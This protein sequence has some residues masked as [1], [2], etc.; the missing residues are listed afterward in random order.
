M[1]LYLGC[2]M[3]PFHEQHITVMGDPD[4]WTWV[5]KFVRHPRVKDWDATNLWQVDDGTA[6]KI[7][8]SHLLEHFPHTKV[9]DILWHWYKKLAKGGELIINVP[10]LAWAA[11]RLNKLDQGGMLDGYYNRFDGDR[12][13]LAIFYGT[14]SH[15]GEYHQAGFIKQYLHDLLLEI[16]FKEVTVEQMEDAHDM[17]VLFARAIK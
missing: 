12:G 13:L 17:G 10:D 9:K 4:A 8:A 3:P 2:A 11:R 1:K 6:E 5:D 15:E 16:G 7:Y 14:Q